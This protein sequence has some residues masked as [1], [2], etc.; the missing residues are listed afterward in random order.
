[1]AR[2]RSST[3][4]RTSARRAVALLV[5]L[6]VMLALAATA[7]ATPTRT[8][9][10]VLTGATTGTFGWC[11]GG[12]W[13]FEGNAVIPSIGKVSFNGTYTAGVIS[14]L[15]P[16]PNELRDLSLTLTTPD[17]STLV[18]TSRLDWLLGGTA[19]PLAW[20]VSEATGRFG[21]YSGT[22]IYTAAA[23][24]TTV[25]ISLSGSLSG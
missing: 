4:A 5:T 24:A 7:Q 14:P 8:I 23:G 20:A 17:G 15:D 22:G 12:I 19:P 1:V 16:Q 25:S 3:S 6:T 21:G 13:F 18:L 9:D 10:S 2:F 11:C